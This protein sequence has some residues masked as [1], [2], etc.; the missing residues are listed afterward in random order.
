M[1]KFVIMSTEAKSWRREIRI[2]KWVCAAAAGVQL[3]FAWVLTSHWSSLCS[4]LGVVSLVHLLFL[5]WC[6]GTDDHVLAVSRYSHIQFLTACC[7]FVCVAAI[8]AMPPTVLGSA[9]C[10]MFPVVVLKNCRSTREVVGMSVLHFAIMVY[11]IK[12]DSILNFD[13]EGQWLFVTLLSYIVNA[14]LPQKLEAMRE[15]IDMVESACGTIQKML[16]TMGDGV[17]VLNSRGL[18]IG[19]DQKAGSIVPFDAHTDMPRFDETFQFDSEIV[20]NDMGDGLRRWRLDSP[21]GE[22]CVVE[23]YDC[24]CF[25][26]WQVLPLIL[27]PSTCKIRPHCLIQSSANEH[28]QLRLRTVRIVGMEH[29]TNYKNTQQSATHEAHIHLGTPSSALE[30]DTC[31]SSVKSQESR[32]S[33]VS[34]QSPI[35]AGSQARRNHSLGAQVDAFMSTLDMV[36]REALAGRVDGAGQPCAAKVM[37]IQRTLKEIIRDALDQTYLQFIAQVPSTLLAVPGS[38]TL[39]V[40]SLVEE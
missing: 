10:C 35:A 14:E 12:L 24:S 4:L 31:A 1:E 26:P 17:F 25:L 37:Y 22:V 3:S 15:S 9:T 13:D 7:G 16:S 36:S 38:Q 30:Q 2:K 40:H 33:E 34:S 39:G 28:Q 29:G 6:A 27:G 5:S 20:G 18:I 32:S 8:S 19:M 11:N 21:D 23:S